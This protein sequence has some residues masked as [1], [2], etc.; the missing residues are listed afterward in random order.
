[1]AIG[2]VTSVRQIV[3]ALMQNGLHQ[4]LP[5]HGSAQYFAMISHL[6]R[7]FAS[8]PIGQE[9][10]HVIF[11]DPNRTY[12]GDGVVAGGSSMHLPVR[13]R[14]LFSRA[15]QIGAGGLI[16]AHN[17]PSG[18]C[19]PSG[20]DIAATNRMVEIGKAL[21]IEIFDHLIFAR[22]KIYSMRAGGKL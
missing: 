17:H 10:F 18:N 1:M 16:L 20:K 22:E 11:L 8:V 4:R 14:D 12:L 2:L 5:I 7:A 15:L 13:L 21:D 6:Q 9:R 19:R 3:N